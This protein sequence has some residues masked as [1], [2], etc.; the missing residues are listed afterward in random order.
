MADPFHDFSAKEPVVLGYS[1]RKSQPT[2]RIKT[3]NLDIAKKAAS[4]AQRQKPGAQATNVL[5]IAQTSSSQVPGHAL[6]TET[7]SVVPLAPVGP[8]S[9]QQMLQG[10]HASAG[11][12][13]FSQLLNSAQSFVP[14][15]PLPNS[16]GAGL[17]F[18]PTDS[19]TR[20][21]NFTAMLSFADAELAEMHDD[22]DA[23]QP[24]P[25]DVASSVANSVRAD[26]SFSMI[27]L[28]PANSQITSTPVVLP[29]SGPLPCAAYYTQYSANSKPIPY[30]TYSFGY[31][32]PEGEGMPSSAS[33]RC[34]VVSGDVCESEED[35]DEAA[36]SMDLNSSPPPQEERASCC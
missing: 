25:H 28:A 31:S 34:A 29:S 1:H 19:S 26:Q 23:D 10:M 12:D 15:P 20:F 7:H 27:D 24:D 35:E 8:E 13:Y 33:K 9:L 21:G 17:S 6:L 16:T 11:Q 18:A 2:A 36:A 30:S 14:S 32:D 22:S 3:F 5:S 4:R